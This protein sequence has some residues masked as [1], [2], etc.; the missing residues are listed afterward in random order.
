MPVSLDFQLRHRRS[1]RS[2]GRFALVLPRPPSPA[3]RHAPALY[4]AAAN[5]RCWTK[6]ANPAVEA[7]GRRA[8][9]TGPYKGKP[10]KKFVPLLMFAVLPSFAIA[11]EQPT[12]PR[13]GWAFPQAR[14]DDPMNPPDWFADE[15]PPLPEVVAH[16]NG[17]TVRA[18]MGC[19][20]ATGHGHPENSRLP[21]T[22][23]SYLA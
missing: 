12:A 5:T 10:M 17:T 6:P 21:G 1:G 11:A 22:T 7:Q 16:G 20:L 4:R 14:I 19:H 18:C 13:P 8:A 3:L 23:A 2:S 9:K 15:H